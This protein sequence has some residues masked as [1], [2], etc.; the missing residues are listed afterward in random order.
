MEAVVLADCRREEESSAGRRPLSA[1]DP[2]GRFLV[3]PHHV[4]S[5]ITKSRSNLGSIRPNR[6]HDFAAIRDDQ[7][8]GC[9]DTI[10]HDVDQQS[11]LA[12]WRPPQDPLP[13]DLANSVVKS[14][15]SVFGVAGCSTRM[16]LL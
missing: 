1:A 13:A 5:R 7:F 4:S 16:T 6:L 15:M 9:R 14:C 8:Y 10:N 2:L 12:C 3:K 11:R